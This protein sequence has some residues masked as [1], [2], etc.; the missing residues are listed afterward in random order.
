MRRGQRWMLNGVTGVSLI[1]ALAVAGLWVGSYWRGVIIEK[2]DAGGN[3]HRWVYVAWGR[4]QFVSSELDT[5]SSAPYSTLLGFNYQ[6]IPEPDDSK[7]WWGLHARAKP[8]IPFW[9]PH[10]SLS[11]SM[12][13]R[14]IEK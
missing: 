4:M 14:D 8:P 13:N 10:R 11:L 2:D 7:I 3:K 5:A 6:F 9:Q 12:P 1:F